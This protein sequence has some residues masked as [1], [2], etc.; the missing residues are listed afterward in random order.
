MWISSRRRLL[1]R[2]AVSTNSRVR[3]LKAKGPAC[4]ARHLQTFLAIGNKPKD[5]QRIGAAEQRQLLHPIGALPLRGDR[6]LTD[7]DVITR[8]GLIEETDST[9]AARAGSR[10]RLIK[11]CVAILPAGAFDAL[12]RFNTSMLLR[13]LPLA[14]NALVDLALQTGGQ[15]EALTVCKTRPRFTSIDV[16]KPWRGLC[17]EPAAASLPGITSNAIVGHHSEVVG[18]RNAVQRSCAGSSA[19][20]LR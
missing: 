11:H 12:M 20:S 5:S 15:P 9:R 1:A 13:P 3:H 6:M 10:Y 2:Q 18:R 7:G 17:T 16:T 8:R 4:V 19:A 14:A